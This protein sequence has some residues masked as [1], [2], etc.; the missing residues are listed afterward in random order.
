M[1]VE[2]QEEYQPAQKKL[3]GQAMNHSTRVQMIAHKIFMLIYLNER[4][5]SYSYINFIIIIIIVTRS[6]DN[7]YIVMNIN[8][9]NN[10]TYKIVQN[11]FT[12]M[13]T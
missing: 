5:E 7:H 10:T 9:Q 3:T 1:T 11:L 4:N 6:A 12:N 8:I 2:E 13:V